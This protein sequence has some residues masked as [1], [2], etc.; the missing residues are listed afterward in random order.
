MDNIENQSFQAIGTNFLK[1]VDSFIAQHLKKIQCKDIYDMYSNFYWDL[2]FFQGNSNGFTG[3]SEYL[4]FRFIYNL[5]GG[6]FTVKS[7]TR[8]LKEFISPSQRIC[9]GQNYPV[10]ADKRYY[11]DVVIFSDDELVAVIQIK[12]YITNG[13]KEINKEIEI[14]N[15]LKKYHPNLQGLFLCFN[16][17]SQK[18]KLL[19]K[20]NS[21]SET[22]DW[23]NFLL[24]DKNEDLLY[25]I[26]ER[27]L[28]LNKI[29][30][31]L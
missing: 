17:L 28:K 22:N 15:K 20:L 5:L 19:S 10:N 7:K 29:Y 27:E 25:K 14:F 3:L 23:F 8:D 31:K 21:E 1:E 4:I 12:L 6:S 9:I 2:K 13:T 26:L 18:S 11:P 30:P 24:L 16:S